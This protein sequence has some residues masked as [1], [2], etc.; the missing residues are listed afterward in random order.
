MS[1]EGSVNDQST[2]DTKKSD[3][4]EFGFPGALGV[5]VVKTLRFSERD[6]VGRLPR[7]LIGSGE[8]SLTLRVRE[9]GES[10]T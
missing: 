8:S 5:F 4:S 10:S 3:S 7:S 2:K 6:Q 9:D 1:E